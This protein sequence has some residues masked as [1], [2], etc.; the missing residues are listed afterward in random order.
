[1][2]A[3]LN[4][5]PV[6]SSQKPLLSLLLEGWHHFGVALTLTEE[7]DRP[8]L[9]GQRDVVTC[10]VTRKV[11]CPE[12]ICFWCT[13]HHSSLRCPFRTPEMTFCLT[14][15]QWNTRIHSYCWYRSAER[16]KKKKKR[17]KPNSNSR[18][19]SF[20]SCFTSPVPS[21]HGYCSLQIHTPILT[22]IG[23]ILIKL[24]NVSARLMRY[25]AS[26]DDASWKPWTDH[27]FV[28]L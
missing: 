10:W 6:N 7:R 1:M 23:Q 13:C 22:Q 28:F 17:K 21:S 20:G 15:S 5:Q 2:H 4:Q 25:Q 24:S 3:A 11:M 12:I 8:L 14:Q 26:A 9:P 27:S 19:F 18:N 16:Q